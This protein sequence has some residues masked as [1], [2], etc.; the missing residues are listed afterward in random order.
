VP[1]IA[2]ANAPNDC[3]FWATTAT[4]NATFW[5]HV[6]A[7]GLATAIDTVT[8]T[9]YWV[10]CNHR[11]ENVEPGSPGDMSSMF[12]PADSEVDEAATQCFEHEA[13]ILRSGTVL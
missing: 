13:V 9:K 1:G 3:L 4:A 10:I 7:N 5:I 6:D 8:G 11:R 12:W 2:E